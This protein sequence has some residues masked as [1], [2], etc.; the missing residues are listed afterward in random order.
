MLHFATLFLIGFL[1]VFLA[2]AKRLFFTAF[3]A[4][5]GF[6]FLTATASLYQRDLVTSFDKPLS[7]G[8]GEVVSRAVTTK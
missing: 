2:V 3:L 5:I 6:S 4:L 8:V 1:D 7:F